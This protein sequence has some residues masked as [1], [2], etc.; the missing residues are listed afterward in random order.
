MGES[1]GQVALDF[2]QSLPGYAASQEKAAQRV[3]GLIAQNVDPYGLRTVVDLGCGSGEVLTLIANSVTRPLRLIGIDVSEHMLELARVRAAGT[4]AGSAIEFVLADTAIDLSGI[5]SRLSE[6]GAG[7][8]ISPR[9]TAI[10]CSGHTIFHLPY[11]EALLTRYRANPLERPALWVLDVH[12]GWD[13]ALEAV[14][15]GQR[16]YEPRAYKLEEDGTSSTVLLFTEAAGPGHVR[17]GLVEDR[18]HGP[19]AHPLV[20]T[21][22]LACSSE[23]LASGFSRAGYMVE[24]RVTGD[25]G[26]GRMESWVFALPRKSISVPEL[27]WGP[28]FARA[29][30]PTL[31]GADQSPLDFV[32][33][34]I[35]GTDALSAGGISSLLVEF[36]PYFD[37]SPARRKLRQEMLFIR[38]V[39]AAS[40]PEPLELFGVY[41]AVAKSLQRRN[42][43]LYLHDYQTGFGVPQS[44]LPRGW[45]ETARA[46]HSRPDGT[47]QTRA[48]DATEEWLLRNLR[49]VAARRE[50][51][52]KPDRED[53]ATLDCWRRSLAIEE[54]GAA[55]TK[56]NIA[57][58]RRRARAVPGSSDPLAVL[59]HDYVKLLDLFH[60]GL[61]R[62]L[63]IGASTR[64]AMLSA[65]LRVARSGNDDRLDTLDIPSSY[66]GSVWIFAVMEDSYQ[67]DTA[68]VLR[69]LVKVSLLEG[70]ASVEAVAADA[71]ASSLRNEARRTA[72]IAIMSRNL[73]HNIGSHVISNVASQSQ[74][75]MRKAKD[76][77]PVNS[78]DDIDDLSPAEWNIYQRHLLL[79]YLQERMDFLAEVST[80]SSYIRLPLSL[81]SVQTDMQRQILLM[82]FIAGLQRDNPVRGKPN[83]ICGLVSMFEGSS[84]RDPATDG[85]PMAA[86]AN[87]VLIDVPGGRNGAQA[88][89]TILENMIRNCA[90][91]R[92]HDRRNDDV[93]I[94]LSWQKS[95]ELARIRAWDNAGNALSREAGKVP[96]VDRLNEVIQNGTVIDDEGRLRRG[97]WGVREIM[98]AAAYLRQIPLEDVEIT[99]PNKP[100]LR[101]LAVDQAGR[102]VT[103][104]RLS[105]SLCY[106]FYTLLPK[107]VAIAD[108]GLWDD[109]S[110]ERRSELL[111]SGVA[112][113]P[114]RAARRAEAGAYTYVVTSE[115][116]TS[117][118]GPV[119][120]VP[121]SPR[122][123]HFSASSMPAALAASK[124]RTLAAKKWE[125]IVAAKHN[126]RRRKFFADA[127]CSLN[128]NLW[129]ETAVEP[130]AVAY[131]RH[132]R[133]PSSPP[134]FWERYDG[135]DDQY[136]VLCNSRPNDDRALVAELTAAGI[137]RIVVLDERVQNAAANHPPIAFRTLSMEEALRLRRILVPPSAEYPLDK[138]IEWKMLTAYL[139]SCVKN[140][141]KSS[142]GKSCVDFVVVHLGILERAV[143]P[144]S[145][146]PKGWRMKPLGWRNA[147]AKLRE[148]AAAQKDRAPEIVICSG[149]GPNDVASADVRFVPASQVER[150]T[151]QAPSKYHLYQLLLASRHPSLQ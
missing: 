88:L 91:H 71:L 70:T 93:Q 65:P 77:A 10:I 76:Q 85:A 101:V 107:L 17:R 63:R 74:S 103:D 138:A 106:E 119:A 5:L 15:Q 9:H 27:L 102:E 16:H 3:L 2:A 52:G 60:I 110:A 83:Q 113:L 59:R 117:P 130:Q 128:A 48:G 147:L 45:T 22:Q 51:A 68:R 80:S 67:P 44:D 53:H 72:S 57:I 50:L 20:V 143:V 23:Q 31:I 36:V 105:P 132:G 98:I 116:N 96:L 135:T 69:D 58:Q 12:E 19:A 61:R 149:R 7:N 30:A 40:H 73:S 148:W 142:R 122:F 62:G 13:R 127:D 124:I 55:I 114:T 28:E 87:D 97:N 21:E 86:P 104:P 136:S 123:R 4:P 34:W 131:V 99:P 84:G 11:L 108:D 38:G 145:S 90:K 112:V 24:K 18:G 94:M 150:W 82:Q 92:P 29:W 39:A 140:G 43:G 26:W 49:H 121:L 6:E 14:N 115:G 32:R 46:S 151:V 89:F 56:E 42:L 133:R 78:G 111:A 95:G 54:L 64:T 141:E 8:A 139:D 100:L 144:K 35:A 81:R 25:S 79:R 134:L 125:A 146:D 109:V 129:C 1:Y 37:A 41:D 75:D 137:A 47:I 126:C 66:R 118:S 120:R 33:E